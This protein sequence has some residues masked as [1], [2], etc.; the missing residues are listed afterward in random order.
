MRQD[1]SSPEEFEASIRRAFVDR[2]FQSIAFDDMRQTFLAS[3][4]NYGIDR[5]WLSSGA[6]ITD[7]SPFEPGTEQYRAYTYHLTPEGREYF[8]LE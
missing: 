4:I 1:E 3:A 2:G 6:D 8:G 5:G 7:E